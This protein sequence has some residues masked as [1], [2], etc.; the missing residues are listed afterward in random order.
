MQTDSDSR[1]L[2]VSQE[3]WRIISAAVERWLD[4]GMISA[5]EA[6]KLRNSYAGVEPV[7]WK[8]LA[9]YYFTIA[10]ICVFLSVVILLT[11]EWL[12]AL[13]AKLSNAP[14]LAKS[15]ALAIIAG[16]FFLEGHQSK[17][18]LAG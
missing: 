1:P 9:Q 16:G 7:S 4:A 11:D 15:I 6:Q 3:E 18:S 17:N 13:F 2:Q 5:E 14:D 12:T 8:K 10:S